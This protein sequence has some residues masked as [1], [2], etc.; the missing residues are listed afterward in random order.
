MFSGSLKFADVPHGVAAIN[1]IPALGWMQMVFLIGAVDYWGIFGD[2]P[3]GKNFLG[4]NEPGDEEK[5]L[6]QVRL[7]KSHFT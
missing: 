5:R 2:Y 4:I 1:A 3:I 6:E 7:P